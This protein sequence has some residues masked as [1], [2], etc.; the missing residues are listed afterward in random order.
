MLAVRRSGQIEIRKLRAHLRDR[1]AVAE[2]ITDEL[3][4]R[5]I[6]H[7]ARLSLALYFCRSCPFCRAIMRRICFRLRDRL[8]VNRITDKI[9]PCHRQPLFV[10]RVVEH[11]IAV[12]HVRHADDCVVLLGF[13][14]ETKVQRKPPRHHHDLLPV[15]KFIVQGSSK[16]KILCLISCCCTHLTYSFHCFVRQRSAAA[17]VFFHPLFCIAPRGN[18]PRGARFLLLRIV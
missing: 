11:R 7:A 3:K 9:Q 6:F 8:P 5:H 16:I 4:L 18:M 17:C 13:S 1:R 15:G 12:R 14:K 2:Q 10:E